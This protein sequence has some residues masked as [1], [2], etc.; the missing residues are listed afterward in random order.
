MTQPRIPAISPRIKLLALDMD[1]TLLNLELEVSSDNQ[2][3]LSAAAERGV[4]V[5]L[6]SGRPPEALAPFVQLLGMDQREGFLIAYNG[7]LIV[8]THTGKTEW[9]IELDTPLLTEIWDLAAECGQPVLTYDAEGI[10]FSKDNLYTRKDCELTGR[11]GRVVSREEFLSKPRVKVILPG[12]PGFLTGVEARFQE[13]FQ[14][15]A[16]MYRSKPYF[17]EIMH[18]EADKG[19]ALERIARLHG[20]RREEVMAIG[21]SWND[22]GML[23]WA[24]V[25][26][27]MANGAEG[28]R[29]IADWVTTR[30]HDEDGVA[31]A[32]DR[33]ILDL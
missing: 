29:G 15:R 20:L 8:E 3:A 25:G 1:D 11:S 24:G 16:N 27:A 33:F 7:S 10:L 32:V 30:D 5:V 9:S 23:R 19:H 18:P 4:Q 12:D 28:I 26:V 14:G 6:A 13:G 22:E 2:R 31:E 21:D 17:F